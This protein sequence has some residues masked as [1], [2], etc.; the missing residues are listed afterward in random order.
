MTHMKTR[1]KANGQSRS[2]DDRRPIGDRD[3]Q[4]RRLSL[5]CA[6]GFEQIV[7]A[8]IQEDL[9]GLRVKGV[10]SGALDATIKPTVPIAKLLKLEYLS[11]VHQVVVSIKRKKYSLSWILTQLSQELS[12]QQ[13]AEPLR[14]DS[15]FRLRII[16]EGTPVAVDRNGRLK[17]E[18]ALQSWSDMKCE[19]R[20]GAMEVWVNLRRESDEAVLSLRLDRTG[21]RRAPK[22]AL[23]PD[24]AAALVRAA[25][26]GKNDVVI[27]PFVGSGAIVIARAAYAAQLIVASDHDKVIIDGLARHLRNTN[28][29][30]V[31]QA[32]RCD[33]RNVV[34]DLVPAHA[35]THVITDLPWGKY[36][37]I[38]DLG[39]LYTDAAGSF[40]ALLQAG[41]WLVCLV[42]VDMPISAELRHHG[43][44]V[45][46]EINV[47]ISGKKAL[48]VIGR[49]GPTDAVSNPAPGFMDGPVGATSGHPEGL[50]L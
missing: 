12:Q 48:V 17:L 1:G 45:V 8:A 43:F 15:S 40:A 18:R 26:H 44:D 13:I 32:H 41:G 10:A 34:P 16:H 20:G 24:V 29:D 28:L 27:D 23:R 46:S 47:L 3:T 39:R 30:T 21:R 9:R 35:A 19:P 36:D 38:E 6:A 33:I 25:P 5:T 37:Q 49:P 22:G 7:S 2:A 31:V 14:R 42:H 4:R 50:C 11:G